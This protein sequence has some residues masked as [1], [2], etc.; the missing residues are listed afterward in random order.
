MKMNHC[1]ILI[2]LFFHTANAQVQVSTINDKHDHSFPFIRS[3]NATV[4]KKINSYLQNQILQN[5]KVETSPDKIF[6]NSKFIHKDTIQQS[7][8]ESI[9]YKVE[10]NNAQVLSLSF[11]FESTG[12]YTS[13]YNEYY[14]FNLQTGKLINAKDLFTSAGVNYLKQFLTRERKKR[15]DQSVKGEVPNAKDS[16]FIIERYSHCNQEANENNIFITPNGIVFYKADCFP[17]AWQAYDINLDIEFTIKQ[18]EKYLTDSGKK[19][20]LK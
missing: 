12:A 15:M 7:G 2:T 16:A 17:H 11:T 14:S 6:E 3:K 13:F 19:L 18:L 9:H 1:F 4:T 5:E 20:L 8:Y 10:R